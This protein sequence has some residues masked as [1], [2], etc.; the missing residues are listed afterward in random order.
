MKA[1]DA[2]RDGNIY[3]K[4][5]FMADSYDKGYTWENVR[6]APT[7]PDMKHGLCP[8]DFVQLPDGRVV[9]IYTRRQMG[10]DPGVMARVSSDDGKT[11]SEVRYRVRRM[12]V[13]G[14]G[15][16]AT[17]AVLADGTILSVCGKNRGNRAM[18]IRWR[19]PAKN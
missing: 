18:A 5:G 14:A 10:K 17:N 3:L 15:T 4:H 16:Y 6:L 7:T 12:R 2:W 13:D 9:W 1:I 8:S 19:L 11:W